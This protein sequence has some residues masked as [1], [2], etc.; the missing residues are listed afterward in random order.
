MKLFKDVMC[1]HC[2][3]KTNILTR[4]KLKDSQYVCSKCTSKIPVMISKGLSDYDYED[5]KE[6]KAYL[7]HSNNE[8]SKIFR[9]NH[10]YYTIHI[11]TEHELFYLD[12][13]YPRVYFKFEDLA[14]FH[15][16]FRPDE[17]KEGFLSSKVTG[18]IHL[19]L[20]MSS[21]YCFVEEVLD[22]SAKAKAEIVN[23]IFKS[24]VSYSNPK[25]MDDF[26]DYFLSTWNDASDRKYRRLAQEL[27]SYDSY[28]NWNY[29]D[30]TGGEWSEAQDPQ[31]ERLQSAKALFMIDDLNCVT[32]DDLKKQRNRLIKTFHTDGGSDADTAYAQKINLAYDVLREQIGQ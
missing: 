8:L 14:D 16:E 18:K 24:K 20:K 7:E 11:D 30:T 12:N 27:E 31:A 32:L 3:N 25:G 10:S 2:G 26:L 28:Y 4:A 6:L 21:P 9:E 1:V 5:F 23:G 15:L 22:Y 13:C 19:K 29:E 17:V